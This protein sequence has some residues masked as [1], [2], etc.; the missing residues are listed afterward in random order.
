MMKFV[1]SYTFIRDTFK[2]KLYNT[3]G[4][5]VN[6]AL[7]LLSINGSVSFNLRCWAPLTSFFVDVIALCH[8]NIVDHRLPVF[9]FQKIDRTWETRP[10]ITLSICKMTKYGFRVLS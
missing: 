6:P 10:N 8:H 4:V 9:W 2:N 1:S 5:I 7:C 3:I